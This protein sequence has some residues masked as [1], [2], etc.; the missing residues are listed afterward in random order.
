MLRIID[1]EEGFKKIAVLQA[2]T[3]VRLYDSTAGMVVTEAM[4]STGLPAQILDILLDRKLYTFFHEP[5]VSVLTE[6]IR[7][8]VLALY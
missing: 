5:N 7:P 1:A 6:S 2:I 3:K 4:L 8:G